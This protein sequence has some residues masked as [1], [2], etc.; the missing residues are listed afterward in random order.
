MEEEKVVIEQHLG[1]AENVDNEKLDAQVEIAISSPKEN[2][3]EEQL[4]SELGETAVEPVSLKTTVEQSNGDSI[5]ENEDLVPAST[6]QQKGG[7]IDQDESYEKQKEVA[8][9]EVHSSPVENFAEIVKEEELLSEENLDVD[10]S[11]EPEIKTSHSPVHIDAGNK[12]IFDPLVYE[13]DASGTEE[14]QAAFM[15]ELENFFKERSLEFK[16]PKFYGEGLNC[17]K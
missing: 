4:S 1:L 16:P 6:D 2:G 9:E 13:G 7:S 11:M 8:K 17:L 14:E 3:N 5:V 12:S 10:V 15:R